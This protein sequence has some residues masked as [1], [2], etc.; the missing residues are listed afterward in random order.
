MYVWAI[1][2]VGWGVIG[3]GVQLQDVDSGRGAGLKAQTVPQD[4]LTLFLTTG[5]AGQTWQRS[6]RC[7]NGRPC[8]VALPPQDESPSCPVGRRDSVRAPRACTRG[9]SRLETHPGGGQTF[10]AWRVHSPKGSLVQQV[11]RIG[12][13]R[14]R[15]DREPDST[16]AYA[17]QGV[18]V[19]TYCVVCEPRSC[20]QCQYAALDPATRGPY[21]APAAARTVAR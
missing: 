1:A 14:L 17:T 2:S 19:A 16:S 15:R 21:W 12:E 5:C 4:A 9:G 13:I 18:V 3:Q 10:T 20:R 8:R 11:L 7:R 6:R